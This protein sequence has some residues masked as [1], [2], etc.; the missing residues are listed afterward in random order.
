MRMRYIARKNDLSIGVYEVEANNMELKKDVLND[1]KYLVDIEANIQLY[2]ENGDPF[3][4][5]VA[6]SIIQEMKK[7]LAGN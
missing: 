3:Y 5:Q 4:L 6:K 7:A 2:E 1:E